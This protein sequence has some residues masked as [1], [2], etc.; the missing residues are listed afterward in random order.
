EFKR[1]GKTILLV[2]HSLGL[3]ERFCDEAVWLDAGE[4]KAEGDPTRVVGTYVTDVARQE[5]RFLKASDAKARE[6]VGAIDA[7][8]T[9]G[10]V[11]ATEIATDMNRAGEGRW[12]SGGVEITSVV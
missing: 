4:K 2:T 12:G 11:D 10:P 7:S 5:E 6:D 8:T 1:R 9:A 3:V